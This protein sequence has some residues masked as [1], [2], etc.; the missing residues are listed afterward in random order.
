MK[1]VLPPTVAVLRDASD[2]DPAAVARIEEGFVVVH[3]DEPDRWTYFAKINVDAEKLWGVFEALAAT[4]PDRVGAIAGIANEEPALLPYADRA[5]VM[6]VLRLFKKELAFDGFLEFGITAQT[7]TEIEEVWLTAEKF[8]K[9]WGRDE[10][11]FRAVMAK[12]ALREIDGLRFVDEFAHVSTTLS[13]VDKS[14][15]HATDVLDEVVE[16]L[17]ALEDDQR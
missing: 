5:E 4:L 10:A 9:V 3:P 16:R 13:Y 17:R 2:V 7:R 8:F 1:L 6:R 11:S 12:L 15:L 14:A